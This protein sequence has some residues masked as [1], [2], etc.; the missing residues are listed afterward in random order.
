MAAQQNFTG[1]E[2]IEKMFD[3][4]CDPE[5]YIKS[6]KFYSSGLKEGTDT[7]LC[8]ESYIESAYELSE[9][10]VKKFIFDDVIPEV[11]NS[12]IRSQHD[13][14][15]IIDYEDY[16]TIKKQAKELYNISL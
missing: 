11:I 7:L 9:E 1:R 4:R 8:E 10:K 6:E 14:K 5:N 3:E 2:K 16:A 13:R 15:I 12:I